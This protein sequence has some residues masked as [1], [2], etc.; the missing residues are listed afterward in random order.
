[1]IAARYGNDKNIRNILVA[2]TQPRGG[3]PDYSKTLFLKAAP[4]N[5]E[6]PLTVHFSAP[7]APEEGTYSIDFGDG[8]KSDLQKQCKGA[9]CTVDASHTYVLR[10]TYAGVLTLTPACN[11]GIC[12]AIRTGSAGVTVRGGQEPWASLS[13][14][15]SLAK[16][17]PL[18]VTFMIKGFGGPFTLEYGDG[19]SKG[20]GYIL[21]GRTI[22][23]THIY[24]NPGTFKAKLVSLSHEY[25]TVTITVGKRILSA[26]CRDAIQKFWDGKIALPAL[27]PVCGD[28]DIPL[29]EP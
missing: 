29:F 7:A 13:A 25:E 16:E 15:P 20:F 12:A 21:D 3:Y 1:M 18:E 10:G 9:V 4:S 17:P 28:G 19:F 14:T 11:T 8:Q 24:K 27:R 5:G 6:A 26:A 23:A 2:L 22:T